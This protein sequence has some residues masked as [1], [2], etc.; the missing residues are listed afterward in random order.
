ML[1]RLST[2]QKHSKIATLSHKWPNVILLILAIRSSKSSS[3]LDYK[4]YLYNIYHHNITC[5]RILFIFIA[6]Q[7]L[8][9]WMYCSIILFYK[10]TVDKVWKKHGLVTLV[11]ALQNGLLT[12]DS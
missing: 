5:S 3:L 2:Q 8:I 9:V 1:N 10:I 4:Q 12:F 11:L 7:Y 6:A